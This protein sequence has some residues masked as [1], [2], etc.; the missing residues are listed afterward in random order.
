MARLHVHELGDPGGEPLVCLHGVT[1]HGRRFERL[2]ARLPGR[3][4]IAPDLRGH[5]RSTYDP[6]WT[7]ERLALDVL[8]TVPDEPLDWLGFSFG[9]R[10]A[11]QVAA[12]APERVR[13]LVLLDPALTV[14]AAEAAERADGA[15]ETETYADADDVATQTLA[16][17]T[18]FRTP[19]EVLADDARE[20]G[21]TGPDGRLT[22]RFSPAMTVTAWS[23]MARDPPPVADVPTLVVTG[24]RSWLPVDVGRLAPARHVVVAGGHPVMWEDPDAVAA[25]VAG[26]LP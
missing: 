22:L 20:H 13:R 7:T 15:R 24:N 14:D 11:A 12:I 1:G 23:E 26:F 16:E 9:G 17:G 6:P 10:I 3:R 25:A 19:H 2:A 4:L 5:G 18:L 8:E 21:V